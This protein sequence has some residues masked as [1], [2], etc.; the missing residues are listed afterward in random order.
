[1]FLTYIVRARPEYEPLL[2]LKFFRGP[3][4]FQIKEHFLHAVQE[5]S[6]RKNYIFW[7]IFINSRNLYRKLFLHNKFISENYFLS[8]KRFRKAAKKLVALKTIYQW[9]SETFLC[10]EIG[11]QI[12]FITTAAGFQ[13]GFGPIRT[14]ENLGNSL[15]NLSNFSEKFNFSETISP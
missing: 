10:L 13:H 8:M 9:L 6:F 1:M 4:R 2:L 12:S 15:I 14:S 3:P 5:K 11:F 7:K